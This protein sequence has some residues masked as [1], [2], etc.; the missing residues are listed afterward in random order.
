MVASCRTPNGD[1]AWNPSKCPD[2]ESNWQ[3]F[4]LQASTQ[5]TETHQPGKH[6]FT[7][8]KWGSDDVKS[9]H[10]WITVLILPFN[11]FTA[12]SKLLNLCRP[13]L[14]LGYSQFKLQFELQIF[15]IVLKVKNSYHTLLCPISTDC[16]SQTIILISV[17][18]LHWLAFY[19]FLQST[20]SLPNYL[21]SYLYW[22]SLFFLMTSS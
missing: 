1:L 22:S 16:W 7:Y 8:K 15:L 13:Q 14:K 10:S 18:W 17:L 4:D 6:F 12:L 2:W 11:H 9:R 21:C 20:I 19:S 5:S 3:I